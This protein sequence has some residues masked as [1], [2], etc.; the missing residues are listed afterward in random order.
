MPKKAERKEPVKLNT[1]QLGHVRERCRELKN[2]IGDQVRNN[3]KASEEAK[4]KKKD[5]E[6]DAK[7][8]QM[9][10]DGDWELK[11]GIGPNTAL[12]DAFDFWGEPTVPRDYH[13]REVNR[14][15]RLVNAVIDE[16]IL[17]SPEKALQD[18]RNLEKEFTIK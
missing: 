16:A 1:V 4:R 12:K 8:I 7:F 10:R 18:L 9:V 15:R 3:F 13:D 17:G 5:P 2:Q 14:L 11:K 6:A